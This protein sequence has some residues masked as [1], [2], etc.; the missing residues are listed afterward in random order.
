[1]AILR[2]S[3]DLKKV[4]KQMDHFGVNS[5]SAADSHSVAHVHH[6]TTEKKGG[7]IHVRF[8]TSGLTVSNS[9]IMKERIKLLRKL[10]GQREFTNIVACGMYLTKE[11]VFLEQSTKDNN[12]P[13]EA[14]LDVFYQTEYAHVQN[15]INDATGSIQKLADGITESNANTLLNEIGKQV[16]GNHP[17][18][19]AIGL[20]VAAAAI[21][22]A[23]LIL[24]G[25]IAVIKSDV[26][27]EFFVGIGKWL[28]ELHVAS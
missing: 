19:K 27:F 9:W 24:I 18:W 23:A 2:Y 15:Y 17:N 20:N 7:V 12:V 8:T 21:W 11:L 6:S 1:M 5:S 14:Q 26:V 10:V 13:T 28:M 22:D 25:V 16:N 3:K 4:L